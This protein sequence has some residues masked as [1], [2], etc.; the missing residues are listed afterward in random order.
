MLSQ[1]ALH[2]QL[3]YYV[4]AENVSRRGTNTRMRITLDFRAL[5]ASVSLCETKSPLSCYSLWISIENV[6]FSSRFQYNS[7]LLSR[8]TWFCEWHPGALATGSIV[9]FR[10][11]PSVDTFGLHFGLPLKNHNTRFDGILLGEHSHSFLILET[12]NFK[13]S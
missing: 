1:L 8:Q 10:K 9:L 5:Y 13:E 7:K 11:N 3:T 4:V 12:R 2:E 6:V